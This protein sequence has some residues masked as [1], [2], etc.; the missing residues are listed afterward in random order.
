MSM[1]FWPYFILINSCSLSNPLILFLSLQLSALN[2]YNHPELNYLSHI[3]I[4]LLAHLPYLLHI[5][6]THYPLFYK[7]TI[8]LLSNKIQCLISIAFAFCQ[9]LN[10]MP[11]GI[12]KIIPTSE[13]ATSCCK[14]S[15]SHFATVISELYLLP[16]GEAAQVSLCNLKIQVMEPNLFA[17]DR[18]T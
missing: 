16:P 12:L 4:F 1:I 11:Q 13:S 14:F 3:L 18:I 2:S 10:M 9:N 6:P 17:P 15:F 5:V 8:Q 7:S